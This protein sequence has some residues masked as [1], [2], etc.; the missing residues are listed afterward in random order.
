MAPIVEEHTQMHN[1]MDI[2]LPK[3]ILPMSAHLVQVAVLEHQPTNWLAPLY[4]VRNCLIQNTN[5]DVGTYKYFEIC[6]IASSTVCVY[7]A[8]YS[9]FNL[10]INEDNNQKV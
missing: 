2:M 5:F 4:Q 6:I 10:I 8:S 9:C 7:F 1:N 3:V